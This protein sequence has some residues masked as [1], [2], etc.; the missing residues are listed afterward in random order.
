MLCCSMVMVMVMMV[1]VVVV[2]EV[3]V[4]AVVLVM[5][6]FYLCRAIH[7]LAE[8]PVVHFGRAA[9]QKAIDWLKHLYG[10]HFK[11]SHG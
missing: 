7:R 8:A 9:E 11:T 6:V 3:V 5:V 1:V 10:Q 2:V 4:V